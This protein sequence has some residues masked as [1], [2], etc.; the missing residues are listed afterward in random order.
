MIELLET[1]MVY[2]LREHTTMNFP[3]LLSRQAYINLMK[4]LVE[5]LR[6]IMPDTR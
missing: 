2:G 4:N 6:N 1:D 3:N 5:K